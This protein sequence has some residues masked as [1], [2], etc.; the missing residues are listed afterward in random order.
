MFRRKES[1]VQAGTG[2]S[3]T[4]AKIKPFLDL[5]LMEEVPLG[6]RFE[7]YSVRS[8]FSSTSA[9]L[10]ACDFVVC[11]SEEQIEHTTVG[12]TLSVS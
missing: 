4:S 6:K 9:I 3:I 2:I 11:F 12:T 10:N 8:K 1:A 5:T 7:T